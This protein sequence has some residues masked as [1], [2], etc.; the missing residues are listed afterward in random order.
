[1]AYIPDI[2]NYQPFYIQTS[3]DTAAIDTTN[4]GLVA[5]ANPFPILPNPKDLY[6]NNWLDMNGEEEYTAKMFYEP[7]ELEVQ[8]YIK[9]FASATMSAEA[10][11]RSQIDE[12]F[13]KIREGEFMIYDSYTGIGR[14]KVRYA[15][16]A[17]ED[18][19]KRETSDG[20]WARSIFTVKFKV[21]D[22]ITRAE[23]ID[24]VIVAEEQDGEV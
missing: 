12:F 5:K 23:L 20:S 17:E 16:F 9:T 11:M 4:W 1:M 13:A 2:V 8:F 24:G 21:N 18:F 14:R 15:G 6:A 22:P 7:I 3:A 19:K 10:V